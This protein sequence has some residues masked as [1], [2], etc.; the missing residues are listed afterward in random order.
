MV[1]VTLSSCLPP[2]FDTK[3]P[4]ISVCTAR[5]AS[6]GSRMPFKIIFPGKIRPKPLD[7]FPGRRCV[8]IV[9]N[10][11]S[12][13]DA[14]G[15]CSSYGAELQRPAFGDDVESPAGVRCPLRDEPQHP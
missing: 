8:E 14:F 6:S 11:S 4:S 10:K 7:V 13:G 15:H 2:W 3:I 9:V 5:L 1:D 12:V